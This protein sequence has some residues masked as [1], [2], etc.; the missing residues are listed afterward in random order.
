M[1][2]TSYLQ[3]PPNIPGLTAAWGT[4]KNSE[5]DYYFINPWTTGWALFGQKGDLK[6]D[7][8]ETYATRKEAYEGIKKL[9]SQIYSYDRIITK[10]IQNEF[11]PA[12]EVDPI[13]MTNSIQLSAATQEV[14]RLCETQFFDRETRKKIFAGLLMDNKINQ[15]EYDFLHRWAE[16]IE[17]VGLRVEADEKL[18]DKEDDTGVIDTM[19][20][21][22]DE[23]KGIPFEETE[24]QVTPQDFFDSDK[25][26]A[27]D[28]SI[29]ENVKKIME[30][31]E[32]KNEEL[33]DFQL[34]FRRMQYHS[35]EVSQQVEKSLQVSTQDMEDFFS[36]NAIAS[37]LLDIKDTTLTD[38]VNKKPA[39][40]VFLIIN[41]QIVFDD[42][43]KGKDE[44]VYSITSEGL[45]KYFFREREQAKGLGGI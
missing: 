43:F 27:P 37:V 18:S 1:D 31:I 22:E 30:Y 32:N 36:A 44:R 5:F 42:T 45:V 3:S 14:M 24:K 15:E 40:L 2:P 4:S 20:K 35:K 12:N 38:N 23:V 13:D 21:S 9:V 6:R 8:V 11:K 39:L 16:Q 19:L 25:D 34:F 7:V 10:E 33:S 17:Q 28:K 29:S 41:N 26:P